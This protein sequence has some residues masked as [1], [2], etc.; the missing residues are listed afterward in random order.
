VPIRLTGL[1]VLIS[2]PR[3]LSTLFIMSVGNTTDIVA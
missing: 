3:F 2:L 1:A